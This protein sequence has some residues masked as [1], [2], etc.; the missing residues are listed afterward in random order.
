MNKD[1]YKDLLLQLLPQGVAWNKDEGSTL[2]NLA[3]GQA[4][5]LARAEEFLLNVLTEINPYTT[6]QLI[7]EWAEIVLN[8]DGCNLELTTQD[9]KKAAVIAKLRSTGGS[10]KIYFQEVAKAAGFL[11]SISDGFEQFR[12]GSSRVGDRVLVDGFELTIEVR[13]PTNTVRYFRADAG[14]AGDPLT[15]FG[16]ALLECL[17]ND[18]KPLHAEMFF[19][20]QD[21]IQ[22]LAANL[23]LGITVTGNMSAV[24]YMSGNV[25]LS[26][27]ANLYDSWNPSYLADL[28]LWYDAEDFSSNGAVSSWSDKQGN[29]DA[30][31]DTVANQ[32]AS[33][34]NT[35]NGRS[36]VRFEAGDVLEVKNLDDFDA[37]LGLHFFMVGDLTAGGGL[38]FDREQLF[39]DAST[40]AANIEVLTESY[41][42]NLQAQPTGGTTAVQLF[43]GDIYT[44]GSD[45]G[46]YKHESNGS[47]TNVLSSLSSAAPRGPME[48]YNNKLYAISSTVNKMYIWDGAT[49][50]EYPNTVDVSG[51]LRDFVFNPADSLF[52]VADGHN[53]KLL[54]FDPAT[55]TWSQKA[56]GL[57]AC[58]SI[59]TDGTNVYINKKDGASSDVF[60]W[61]G[62]SLTSEGLSGIN[63]PD[64]LSWIEGTLWLYDS[65]TG[66][67][68]NK[69]NSY[70]LTDVPEFLYLNVS[71]MQKVGDELWLISDGT[72]FDSMARYQLDGTNLNASGWLYEEDGIT[73]K[74]IDFGSQSNNRQRDMLFIP[75]TDDLHV[76]INVGAYVWRV[77]RKRFVEELDAIPAQSIFYF[78]IENDKAQIS[79][80]GELVQDV[81]FEDET[82]RNPNQLLEQ[83][84]ITNGSLVT[85]LNDV[86]TIN[87]ASDLPDNAVIEVV[88]DNGAITDWSG[89][90]DWT[91]E[92]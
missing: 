6:T 40:A 28:L 87:A 79:I 11:T 17:L 85:F 66:K 22:Y 30:I 62:S 38:L 23:E 16:N 33:V 61:N 55:N 44:T 60:K 46:M 39:L 49:A 41:R 26:I 57:T 59:E 1:D 71:N 52:Y 36:I 68:T 77:E 74:V 9:E 37:N 91:F 3:A 13:S 63:N 29:R 92:T 83:I 88:V 51:D 18:I 69:A 73:K 42:A 43:Q 75:D 12:A 56:T 70:T 34:V 72:Y 27:G 20:Y 78:G 58:S 7:D 47:F 76:Y 2:S 15:Y 50:A 8:T 32:P 45:F 81:T 90:D 10:D 80:N 82:Y 31:Q 19:R 48:V 35:M 24:R 65:T 64:A 5:E 54:A 14:R 4:A 67:L 89:I 21:I 25:P 53:G 86:V 84:A